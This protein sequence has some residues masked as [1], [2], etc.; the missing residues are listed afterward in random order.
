M[1]R[2][3]IEATEPAQPNL[4]DWFKRTVTEARGMRLAAVH[5]QRAGDNAAHAKFE[6]ISST[7]ADLVNFVH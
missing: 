7:L 4:L 2:H 6:R 1:A 3:T 5:P